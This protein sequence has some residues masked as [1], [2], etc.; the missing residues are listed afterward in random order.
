MPNTAA[1]A[2]A[3]DRRRR[4]AA[5]AAVIAIRAALSTLGAAAP[6]LLVAAGELRLAH[7]DL[8]LEDLG[9]RADPPMSKEVVAG[10]IRRLL[11][12]AAR[13]TAR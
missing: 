5:A 6:A 4:E 7:P 11:A 3:N 13:Q 10:R 2:P 1:F 9:Q 8:S 12:L